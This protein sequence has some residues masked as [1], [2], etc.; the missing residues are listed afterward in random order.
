MRTR[1]GGEMVP[2]LRRSE[3]SLL[4]IEHRGLLLRHMAV[5]RAE[6]QV[7]DCLQSA[8]VRLAQSPLLLRCYHAELNFL[9]LLAFSH[10]ALR[11]L[12][13]FLD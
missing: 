10:I 13:F 12:C 6:Q 4:N 2:M 9:G 1:G 5:R 8:A 3:K 11:A 7:C